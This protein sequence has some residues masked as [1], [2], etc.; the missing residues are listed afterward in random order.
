MVCHVIEIEKHQQV[1]DEKVAAEDHAAQAIGKNE[2]A[3]VES[4]LVVQ[5]EVSVATLLLTI[6]KLREGI[7]TGFIC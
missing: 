6:T 1:E 7:Q 5:L 3:K 2:A 4:K